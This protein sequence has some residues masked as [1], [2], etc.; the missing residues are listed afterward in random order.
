L[1]N[2]EKDRKEESPSVDFRLPNTTKQVQGL[3]ILI[4]GHGKTRTVTTII[5]IRP[6]QVLTTLDPLAL[7]V[8]HH[9]MALWPSSTIKSLGVT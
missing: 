8:T 5:K 4:S 7:R 3:G 2:K 1:S 6:Y 9:C